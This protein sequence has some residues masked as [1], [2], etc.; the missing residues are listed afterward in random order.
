M[1]R[2]AIFILTAFLVLVSISSCEKGKDKGY[3]G[4]NYIYLSTENDPVIVESEADRGV[5]VDIML[6]TS[7]DK[8]IQLNFE[9]LNDE[10]GALEIQG[11][12]VT[13]KAGEKTASIKVVSLNKGVLVTEK[14]VEVS[15][16][17]FPDENI[18]LKETLKIRFKPDPKVPELTEDQKNMIEGYKEKFGIDIYDFMGAVKYT[19][20]IMYPGNGSLSPFIGDYTREFEGTTIITLSEKATADLPVLK[21]VD[22]PMGLTEYLYEIFRDETIEDTEYKVGQS[23]KSNFECMMDAVGVN[24]DSE[25]TF[26]VMLDSLVIDPSEKTVEFVRDVADSYGYLIKGVDFRY[27][28][29]AWD[30][31]KKMAEDGESIRIESGEGGKPQDIPASQMIEEGNTLDPVYYLR[32]SDIGYDSWENDPSDFVEPLSS[33]D[34]EK[35]EM[36]FQFS[37]DHYSAGGYAR[38]Y[39]TYKK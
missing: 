30:R 3:S 29:T 33:I 31:L 21:M 32:Y 27:S 23:P 5:A 13:I 22:N 36:T 10:E 28:Y 2:T 39:V 19:L 9:I 15:I 12:P 38:I 11:N 1:K 6:T 34:F 18:Q 24:K 7:L 20:M 25:E 16:S 35:G 17:Q 37:F 26:S 4:I 14:Y 8:D